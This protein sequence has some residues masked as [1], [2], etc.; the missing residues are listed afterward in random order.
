MSVSRL[1]AL[2][3]L[4]VLLLLIVGTNEYA[5]ARPSRR[6]QDIAYVAA[7]ATDFSAERHR[8]DVYTPRRKAAASHPVVVFI[9]G[10]NWDSGSKNIYT[11]IGRRLA[12]QGVVAV[13]I[14][15]RLSPD[16]QVPAMAEDCARAVHWTQQH[17]AEYGGDP[18]R[19]FLM[20]HSAGAGLAALIATDNHYFSRL[21]LLQNSVRGVILDDPAGLDMYDYLLKKQYAGDEQY[22]TAFG[23]DPQGWKAVS[24][25]Y[26]LTA[27]S[28]PFLTFVGGKTYPSIAS[29]SQKF[30][31]RLK[32]LGV[33]P[34]FMVLPG[35]QHIPMV[36]QLYWQHNVIYRQ[37]LPFI[38]KS[39]R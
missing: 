22:L 15:Y 1:L 34:Q 31:S 4:L 23:R 5:V 18:Q 25:L 13:I 29:S 6:T 33:S 7:T 16:V 8:L 9:H 14:N 32:E 19:I 26:H 37:L 35:K 24:A 21:G 10:G 39:S 11:F 36:L 17:I 38:S 2:P 27:A 20:G 30:R 28:P 3:A 12:K